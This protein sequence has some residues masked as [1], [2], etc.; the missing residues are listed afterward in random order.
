MELDVAKKF[1]DQ[2]DTIKNVLNDADIFE[3]GN[4]DSEAEYLN[5]RINK[6]STVEEIQTKLWNTFF[7]HLIDDSNGDHF[8]IS[9]L[10][11]EGLEEAKETVGEPEFLKIW[12]E[13]CKSL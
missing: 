11:E 8:D 3:F 9:E 1:L 6:E 2:L 5:K 12:R 13:N 4:Y 10:S 7:V